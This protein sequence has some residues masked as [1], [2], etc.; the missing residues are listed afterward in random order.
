MVTDPA[1]ALYKIPEFA[2]LGRAFR[3]C[4]EVPLTESEMEYVV[5]SVKH[6]FAQHIVLQFSVVN[7]IDDQRL[8]DV[9]VVVEISD[10][11][12]Y[13]VDSEVKAPVAKYGETAYCYVCLARVANEDEG[14]IPGASVTLSCNLKFNVVQVDPTTGEV[15]G[16]ED[17]YEEEYAL[18]SLDV[19]TNDFMAKITFPDFRR[20]WEQTS[21]EG[22]VLEKFALQFKKL[23]EAVTA[24]I[25]F[26]GMQ[27]CDNTGTV[28]DTSVKNKSHTLHLSGMFVGNVTVL[29]RAQLQLD[30]A[31]GGVVLKIAVRSESKDI[32]TLVAECIR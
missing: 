9:G 27:P 3:S 20:L 1:S 4:P 15:E 32:S 23:S 24:V 21:T 11:D 14:T 5:T 7:T 31:V 13:A 22:E 26:L 30:D 2:H 25:D 29:V 16:D 6:I 19:N 28:T 17:G 18:E 12:L 8:K 10:E